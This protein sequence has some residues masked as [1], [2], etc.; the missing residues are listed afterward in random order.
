MAPVLRGKKRID[1]A[2]NALAAAQKN[3]KVVPKRKPQKPPNNQQNNPQH[4]QSQHGQSQHG[5]PQNGQEIPLGSR[6]TRSP[7]KLRDPRVNSEGKSK[8]RVLHNTQSGISRDR[9]LVAW[10]GTLLPQFDVPRWRLRAGAPMIVLRVLNLQTDTTAN[11]SGSIQAIEVDTESDHTVP[12]LNDDDDDQQL[13]GNTPPPGDPPST[14]NTPPPKGSTPPT[15]GHTPPS[16]GHSPPSTGNTP[17]PGDNKNQGDRDHAISVSDGDFDPTLE[18]LPDYAPIP[19]DVPDRRYPIEG[20]F[21]EEDEKRWGK[22]LSRFIRS[23]FGLWNEETDSFD[24]GWVGH[25]TLGKGGLGMAGLWQKKLEDGT[26]EVSPC[27][28][29]RRSKALK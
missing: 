22:S 29:R 18:F 19:E 20:E 3:Q 8:P 5:Q 16:R 4:G 26:V 13:P 28:P 14:G 15:R 21:R 24:P 27:L 25:K 6:I 7:P 10:R 11:S 9:R 17:P 2:E 1:Y 12:S 23:P